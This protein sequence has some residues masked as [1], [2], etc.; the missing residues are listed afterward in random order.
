MNQAGPTCSGAGGLQS[1]AD[2]R[3]R[4]TM[5]GG[6]MEWRSQLWQAG[7]PA[8]MRRRG[9]ADV[10]PLHGEGRVGVQRQLSDRAR[11]AT[12]ASGALVDRHPMRLPVLRAHDMSTGFARS[13]GRTPGF[14]VLSPGYACASAPAGL[15]CA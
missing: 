8:P 2:G 9:Q 4:Q 10:P 12:T 14:T 7:E 3:F 11:I 1:A 13:G 6:R 15:D 5:P